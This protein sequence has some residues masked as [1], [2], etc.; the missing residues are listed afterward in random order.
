MTLAVPVL[1]HLVKAQMQEFTTETREELLYNKE[2]LLANGDRA[3][4][5]IAANLHGSPSP[6][7]SGAGVL[8]KVFSL[9]RSMSIGDAF[10]P[11]VVERGCDGRQCC[12]HRDEIC[13]PFFAADIQKCNPVYLPQERI[14]SAGIASAVGSHATA[15]RRTDPPWDTSVAERVS[16]PHNPIHSC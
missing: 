13:H 7:P 8:T 15:L 3:E 4:A 10:Q 12:G 2:K 9:Q 6:R 5:E 11:P 14:R 16:S 1:I